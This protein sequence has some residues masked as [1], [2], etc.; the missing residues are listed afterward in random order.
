MS[1]DNDLIRRGDALEAIYEQNSQWTR[2]AIAD[3]PAAQPAPVTVE[4]WQPIETA[5]KDALLLGYEDGAI[6]LVFWESESW[7][8]VGASI[9]RSWFE[10]THW[11][12]LP[13]PPALAG[14]KP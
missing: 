4:A 11:M 1:D 7:K 5:P 12:R 10:P 8:V 3:L 2:E 14:D 9:K 6:R 13:A